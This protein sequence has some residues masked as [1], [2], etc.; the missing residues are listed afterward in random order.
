[1][2]RRRMF[3]NPLMLACLGGAVVPLVLH[4]L[5][6]ARYVEV[7]WGAMMFLQGAEARQRYSARAAQYFLLLLRMASVALLAVALARPLTRKAAAGTAEGQRL[8][9][10]LLLDCSGSMAYEENGRSRFQMGQAAARQILR[11]LEP[12]DRVSLILMGV[13]QS[14]SDLEPT[15]DLRSVEARI[16]DA[17]VVWGR[18]DLRDALNRAADVLERYERSARDVYVVCDRQALSWNQISASVAEDWQKRFYGPADQPAQNA[19]ERSRM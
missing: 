10:A 11:G 4:L 1:M 17:R 9:A 7:E 18:A 5:S 6:R 12:G 15:A 16:N 14:D 2:T 8:T 3:L 13:A 19:R